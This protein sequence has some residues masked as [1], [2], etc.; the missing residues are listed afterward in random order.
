MT[1]P[2]ARGTGLLLQRRCPA[3]LAAL[4]PLLHDVQAALQQG[5]AAG[6]ALH[7][8]RLVVEE[9]CVNVVR[10]AF[11]DAPAPGDLNLMIERSTLDHLPALRVTLCDAGQP[12][13]PLAR[14][15]PDLSVPAEDRAIG[16]LG[17][18]LIRSL[19]DRQEYRHDGIHGNCLVLYKQL[20]P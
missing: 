1:L 2:A 17:V 13:D 16:G 18:H 19:T 15:A 3:T 14:A 6:D 9:A 8:L 20:A 5:G 10:H 7:D 12:F 4:G 11:R